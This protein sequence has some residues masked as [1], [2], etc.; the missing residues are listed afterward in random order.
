M[1]DLPGYI[2]PNAGIVN[3]KYRFAQVNQYDDFYNPNV[4]NSDPMAPAKELEMIRQEGKH[5]Y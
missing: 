3:Q 4:K 1:T 5:S 2:D